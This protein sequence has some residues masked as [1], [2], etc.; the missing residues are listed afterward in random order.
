[1]C[2]ENDYEFRHFTA[3]REKICKRFIFRNEEENERVFLVNVSQFE[4]YG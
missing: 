4:R 1:M 2:V 3:K